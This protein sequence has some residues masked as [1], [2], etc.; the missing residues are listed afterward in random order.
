[1][2]VA[3]FNELKAAVIRSKS[4]SRKNYATNLAREFFSAE[5]RRS[6]N[7]SGSCGER[8]L[9]EKKM[10]VICSALTSS[11]LA[12]QR[13]H[14]RPGKTVSKLLTQQCEFCCEST[15]KTC[16]LI[17]RMAYCIHVYTHFASYTI[18]LCTVYYTHAYARTS[19]SNQ[20]HTY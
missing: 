4:C 3:D 7:V 13:G 10:E 16:R 12:V 5:E 19:H 11:H 17:H 20:L 15:K 1:M 8:K 6:S 9:D 14:T 2:Q 18:L